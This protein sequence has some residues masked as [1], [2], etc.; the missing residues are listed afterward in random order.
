MKWVRLSFKKLVKCF[1]KILL[2]LK[3]NNLFLYLRVQN[4]FLYNCRRVALSESIQGTRKVYH[5]S[6]FWTKLQIASLHEDL[7]IC[8]FE[9]GHLASVFAKEN[10]MPKTR[11]IFN[12]KSV[13]KKIMDVILKLKFALFNWRKPF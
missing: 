5:K 11:Y 6:H 13:G 7:N 12:W 10:L 1:G 4:A 9:R 3:G 2:I 8:K